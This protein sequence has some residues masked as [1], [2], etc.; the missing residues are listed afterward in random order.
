MTIHFQFEEPRRNICCVVFEP[1]WTW[2]ELDA[3]IEAMAAQI[4]TC[5]YPVATLTDLT[6]F[7]PL[8]GGDALV[9]LQRAIALPDNVDIAILV[10]A[11]YALV[12]VVSF[13]MQIRPRVQ[14]MTFFAHSLDEGR[15]FIHE[16]RKYHSAS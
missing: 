9:H 2:D 16:R 5:D 7:G 13:L 4:C 15:S 14:A 8:P 11:P 3:Q 12:N 6:R 10:N 1:F